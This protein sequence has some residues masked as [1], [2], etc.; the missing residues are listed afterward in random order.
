MKILITG[1]TGMIG[2][3]LTQACSDHSLTLLGRSKARLHKHFGHS[4]DYMTWSDISSESLAPFDI[5]VNLAGENIGSGRWSTKKKSRIFNS[6][7]KATTKIVTACLPLGEQSP[8]LINASA[9]GIYG[10]AKDINQQMDI[11][12]DENSTPPKPATDFISHVGASWESALTPAIKAHIPVTL[13]RFAVVLDR[14]QGALAKL[15][16]TFRLGLGSTIASGKQP[17]SWVSLQDVVRAIRFIIDTPTATGAFNIVS[18]DVVSQEQFAKTLATQLHRPCF[19]PLPELIVKL[20]FGQMGDELL[21]QGQ[22]VKGHRLEE[23]GFTFQD[24]TL[25]SALKKILSN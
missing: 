14:S 4:Y 8:R 15:L 19:L 16:P 18:E 1:A 5:I 21:I 24:K 23:F 2:T 17:F 7:I 9:I 12:F 11:I 6:R 10:L 3:A 22:H 25:D 13:L 20:L